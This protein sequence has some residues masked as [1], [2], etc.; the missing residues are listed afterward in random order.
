[1]PSSHFLSSQTSPLSQ[2]THPTPVSDL[3]TQSFRHQS[4]NPNP[5]IRH[6]VLRIQRSLHAALDCFSS[7]YTSQERDFRAFLPRL[8]TR[9]P[10]YFGKSLAGAEVGN[11]VFAVVVWDD[12][13]S[14]DDAIVPL[15]GQDE[16]QEVHLL[17]VLGPPDLFAIL[18]VSLRSSVRF[19]EVNCT[20]RYD[21]NF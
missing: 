21:T 6:Q 16:L 10:R 8:L 3:P 19:L 1:M 17:N 11:G 2:R 4:R 5:N 13:E 20:F 14:R 7:S 12:E 18:A 15:E 9:F